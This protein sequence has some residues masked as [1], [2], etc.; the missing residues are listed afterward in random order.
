[1][2]VY[3]FLYAWNLASFHPSDA[4]MFVK[5]WQ[6]KFTIEAAECTRFSQS[7]MVDL[8]QY[9]RAVILLNDGC[10]AFVQM[11][12]SIINMFIHREHCL[13]LC[14]WGKEN[15]QKDNSF[16]SLR[17]WHSKLFKD[18]FLDCRVCEEEDQL[19]WDKSRDSLL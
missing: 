6:P 18:A 12:D 15:K 11:D 4:K 9:V 7:T 17:N 13:K 1:M 3:Y 5:R 2:F 8:D 10:S 14:L 19:V 16:H